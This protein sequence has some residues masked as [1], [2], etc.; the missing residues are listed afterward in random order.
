MAFSSVLVV[1]V[2]ICILLLVIE[3]ERRDFDPGGTISNQLLNNPHHVLYQYNINKELKRRENCTFYSCFDINRC[4]VHTGN[5]KVH[6]YPSSLYWNGD[7][8][9][10]PSQ[11]Y[12]D[13]LDAIYNSEF[14]SSDPELACI[15]V[16][17]LDT[18]NL[19]KHNREDINSILPELEHWNQGQNHLLFNIVGDLSL[20]SEK[21]ILGST[22]FSTYTYRPLFDI[23]LPYLVPDNLTYTAATGHP[24]SPPGHRHTSDGQL[25]SQEGDDDRPWS[26]LGFFDRQDED[27]EEDLASVRSDDVVMPYYCSATRLCFQGVEYTAAEMMTRS[28]FCLVASANPATLN[29]HL[30]QAIKAGCVPVIIQGSTILPF[31]E[32]IDWTLISIRLRRKSVVELGNL[33]KPWKSRYP[34]LKLK[35]DEVYRVYLSDPASVALTTIR[36]INSR[37]NTAKGLNSANWNLLQSNRSPLSLDR[38]PRPNAGFT[39][40][41]LS[42]D[43]IQSLYQI[44]RQISEVYSLSRIVVVWNHETKPPPPPE[45][46]PKLNKQ[47]K[48]VQTSGNRLSNRFY[49]YPEIE[50]ECVLSI[51]DDITMLTRDEIEFGFQ[52]W[53]E[54][55]DRIVGFPSRTHYWS[56]RSRAW[57]YESEWKNEHSIILT[58]AAFYNKYW[59]YVYTASPDPRQASIRT[60]VDENMN[61]EDIA[62]NFMVAN[63]TNLPPV[64]IGPRKKF[65]CATPSC[66][67]VSMLSQDSGHL[68]RRSQCVEMFSR[69]YGG[70]PL[71][72]VEYR[73]DP[74]LYKEKMPHGINKYSDL[75]SL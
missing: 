32:I 44:I 60:W 14:Y 58:G 71:K 24:I 25:K 45:Q 42:Y 36:I 15:F 12:I 74:L 68:A 26:L 6:I 40:V 27:L 33:V 69:L 13:I 4:S 17:S 70:M 16:P 19:N 62:F 65:R 7:T 21:A 20:R 49:P 34:T 35:L 64:K 18:L 54:F 67:N 2:L 46:W 39:A 43:R 30:L 73:F 48:V 66:E 9:L 8:V 47:L 63:S 61:C 11:E 57:H 75:G 53:R 10:Q 41:I 22:V 55:P 56:N 28:K 23:S 38:Y 29:F 5:I 59:H 3:L 1:V 52:V 50:T 72:N 31:S 37:I 51:D